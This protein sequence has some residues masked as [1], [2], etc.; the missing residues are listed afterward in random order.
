MNKSILPQLETTSAY[1]ISFNKSDSQIVKLSFGWKLSLLCLI[2][3]VLVIF[4]ILKKTIFSEEQ[5]IRNVD[6]IKMPVMEE[7]MLTAEERIKWLNTIGN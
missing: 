6:D 3:I 1:N 7:K 5:Y 4:I 2:V